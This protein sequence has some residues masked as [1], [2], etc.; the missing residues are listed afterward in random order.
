MGLR[1]VT[2]VNIFCLNLSR[3]LIMLQLNIHIIPSG[4]RLIP[5]SPWKTWKIYCSPAHSLCKAWR[6]LFFPSGVRGRQG[7]GCNRPVK[8]LQSGATVEEK[9]RRMKGLRLVHVTEGR[10][11]TEGASEN[12][13][14]KEWKVLE[15]HWIG[16]N[17]TGNW[18]RKNKIWLRFQK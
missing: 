7:H 3:E 18:N 1:R 9:R 12:T 6:S 2:Q 5:A 11:R 13:G 16:W 15:R 14:L 17:K 4:R 8:C 10:L